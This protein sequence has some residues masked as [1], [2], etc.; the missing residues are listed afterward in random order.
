MQYSFNPR[1]MGEDLKQTRRALDITLAQLAAM[2]GYTRQTLG[3]L[4]AGGNVGIHVL[5]AALAAMGKGLKI[6]DV[7]A[8]Y[9]QL[10]ELFGDE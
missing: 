8:D 1:L 10:Q 7:R 4:E 6:V 9:D 2:T 3:D 5:M